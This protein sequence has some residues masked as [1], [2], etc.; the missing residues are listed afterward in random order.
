MLSREM[1][2]DQHLF[3]T[4]MFMSETDAVGCSDKTDKESKVEGVL[5]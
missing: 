1:T 3:F 4:A 2:Q 5:Q